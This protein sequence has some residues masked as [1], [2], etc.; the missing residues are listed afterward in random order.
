M[1]GGHADDLP[2]TL[3]EDADPERDAE[4]SNELDFVAD[5]AAAAELERAFLEGA[6]PS[7]AGDLRIVTTPRRALLWPLV[8][9]AAAI[10]VTLFVMRRAAAPLVTDPVGAAVTGTERVA[11]APP[12]YLATALRD[13]AA[14]LARDYARAMES[15]G[16]GDYARAVVDL[17]AFL[18]AHPAH[19]SA[20]FYAAAALEAT[21]A[22]DAARELYAT[23]AN[24]ESGLIGD[25]ALWRLA[26]LELAHGDRE[27]AEA[28]LNELVERAGVFERNARA[29]LEGLRE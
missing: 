16:R 17:R 15:Y 19:A 18:D 9:A 2:W 4:A 10:V 5:F 21:E 25:H 6:I 20:A 12:A 13:D 7:R 28:S 1:S 26:H 29:L 27:R 11:L 3:S 24:R 22:T 23:V 14:Q 8:A